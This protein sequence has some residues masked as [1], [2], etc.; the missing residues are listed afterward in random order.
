MVSHSLGNGHSFACVSHSLA[1]HHSFHE[2]R[3]RFQSFTRST[4]LAYASSPS[5]VY[6]ESHSLPTFH[7]FTVVRIRWDHSTRSADLTFASTCPLVFLRLA[8]ASPTS[9]VRS[10]SYS[11]ARYHS[12]PH[13]PAF[14]SRASLACTSSHSLRVA[15]SLGRGRIRLASSTRSSIFAF[16]WCTSLVTLGSHSISTHHSFSARRIR[17]LGVH[18]L[19]PPRIRCCYITRFDA[20]AFAR[21]F[22]HTN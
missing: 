18:S 10:A 6:P 20:H 22:A 3:I 21:P 5:L 2:N 14:A 12:L 19:I 17:S 7:S 9:L 16:A 11:L 8:F 15:H 13:P 1:P 4:D